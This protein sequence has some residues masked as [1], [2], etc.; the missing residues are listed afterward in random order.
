MRPKK[1]RRSA[2]SQE[3]RSIAAL[4][5]LAEFEQFRDE[6]LPALQ[7]D[8]KKGLEAK[9]I[10]KKYRAIAAAKIVTGM[11]MPTNPLAHAAAKEILDRG[12]GKATES[13]KVEHKFDGVHTED[14]KAL[15]KSKL[16]D[17]GEE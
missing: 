10:I 17:S 5:T 2:N 14:L 4:D 6:I 16:A 1:Y 7:A 9:E 13:K 12:D 15:L 3:N 8:L 11:F